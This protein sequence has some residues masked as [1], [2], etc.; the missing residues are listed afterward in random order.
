MEATFDVSGTT[1][2][3]QLSGSLTVPYAAQLKNILMQSLANAETVIVTLSDI[4]EIDL[5]CIQLLCSAHRMS[6]KMNKRL[7][8]G[9]EL[10]E[11]FRS[12]VGRS[13]FRRHVGCTLDTQKS[14][15]WVG[16]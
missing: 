4:D 10:P 8:F 11:S 7:L 6:V 14:C 16:A 5:S 9:G 3:V 12:A 15:V 13:G 2:A 1:G